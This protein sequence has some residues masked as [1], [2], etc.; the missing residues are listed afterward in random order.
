VTSRATDA[1]AV[2][3]GAGAV[4]LAVAAELART[5]SVVVLERHESY[6]RETTAHNSGVI[7]AGIYYP[8]GSWK[9]RLCLAGNPALYAWCEAHNVP[10]RQT[11]KLIVALEG[12]TADSLHR[13]AAQARANDVPGVR[14]LTATEA[15]QL[16]PVIPATAALLS[17][18]SGIIDAL[19]YT[20][21]LE[22]AARERGALVAYRHEVTAGRRDADGFTLEMRDPDGA[23]AT[24]RTA[25]VVN[26]A[27]L[28]APALA[29]LLGYSLDRGESRLPSLRQHVNRG[30]YYDV[31]TPAV[32]RSVRHLVYPLPRPALEGLGVHLTLDLD[33]GLHLGPD[34]EWLPADAVLDYRNDDARRAEF[35]TAGRRLLPQLRDEDIAPGQVG[36]RPKRSGPGE[37]EADFLLWYDR[38]YVHLG[39]IESPGLTASLPLATAV[40]S[41]LR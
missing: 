21:S 15:A 24:L 22:A 1:D 40:A 35:L 36:Y 39:G 26:S 31:V 33:G 13:V 28:G 29:E 38:G 17:E 9:H 27:G 3:V 19:A 30:R 20:R 10:A 11:G 23:L 14:P 7:H 12:D 6:G 34:T 4:G 2:I 18:S 41:M 32:A 25:A 8:T 5:H 37:P 16:E